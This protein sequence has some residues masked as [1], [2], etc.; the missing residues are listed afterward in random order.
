MKI[1]IEVDSLDQISI[2]GRTVRE[3][4]EHRNQLYI[5]LCST[6]VESCMYR[7]QYR[8]DGDGFWLYL[9]LNKQQISYYLPRRLLHQVTELGI[10]TVSD[11]FR[12]DCHSHAD[13]LARLNSFAYTAGVK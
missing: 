7:L 11:S 2:S 8:D 13:I 6:M 12:D 9:E 1:T 10:N 4:Q 5:A 3:L